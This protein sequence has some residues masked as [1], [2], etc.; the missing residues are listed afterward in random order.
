MVNVNVVENSVNS[1]VVRVIVVNVIVQYRNP[2]MTR[3]TASI[4][5]PSR[6]KVKE[7]GAASTDL[8]AGTELFSIPAVCA[9][10]AAELI[11]TDVV[12]AAESMVVA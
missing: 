9:R 12:A 5:R 2:G 1:H 6:P 8:M 11:V 4:T 3:R 10:M 7:A